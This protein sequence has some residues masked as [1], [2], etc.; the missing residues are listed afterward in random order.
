MPDEPAAPSI[1]FVPTPIGNLADITLRGIETLNSVDLIACEDTRHSRKLLKHYEIDKAL[2]SLHDHNESRK[3]PEII[4]KA[5]SG[6][7]IA[8]ISDAGT[9]CLSDP[10]YRLIRAC[11]ENSIR[12]VGRPAAF[13]SRVL[14]PVTASPV[15]ARAGAASDAPAASD[16]R[17][18]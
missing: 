17:E 11:I 7:R 1:F 2:T 14:T 6:D 8:V 16:R 13:K 18:K 12:P 3:I 15:T 5:Q 9:P 4:A 10:G